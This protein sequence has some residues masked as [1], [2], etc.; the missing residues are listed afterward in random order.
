ME[1]MG[2]EGCNLQICDMNRITEQYIRKKKKSEM[3]QHS[4]DDWTNTY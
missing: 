1:K 2:Q 4:P 3:K